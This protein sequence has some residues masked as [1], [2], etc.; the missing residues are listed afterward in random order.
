M[1]NNISSTWCQKW[2][3]IRQKEFY[4]NVTR[5]DIRRVERNVNSVITDAGTAGLKHTHPNGPAARDKRRYD[6]KDWKLW[7][8]HWTDYEVV[9][10]LDKESAK[11]RVPSS[12]GISAGKEEEFTMDCRSNKYP[13]GTT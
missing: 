4:R 12:E 5:I 2:A 8:E 7:R 13:T 6:I 3:L 10:K 11:Y 1:L 9:A